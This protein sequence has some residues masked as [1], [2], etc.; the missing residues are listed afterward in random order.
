MSA[1]EGFITGFAGKLADDV[2]ERKKEARDYF[3]K[4]VE[5]ART[6][7]LENRR[8][9]RQ[10]VD[11][12]IL[13]AQQ[14]RQINVPTDVIANQIEANP[15]GLPSLYQ[16]AEKIRA[17]VE[18]RTGRPMTEEEWKTAFNVAKDYK[19]P[20]E[21]ISSLI[22]RAYSPIVEAVSDPSSKDDLEGNL[23]SR[24]LG[25]NAMDQARA[26]LGETV[27][28]DGMTAEQLIS[29]GDGPSRN[30]S[31][32][33]PSVN[34]AALGG[35]DQLSFDQITQTMENIEVEADKLF[36]GKVPT[37]TTDVSQE[38]AELVDILVNIYKTPA[39]EAERL[40]DAYF[41][42]KGYG[43]NVTSAPQDLT[44]GPESDVETT[45][46]PPGGDG[47]QDTQ[48]PP[49]GA[50]TASDEPLPK[51]TAPNS[52]GFPDS[53][54]GVDKNGKVVKL[55]LVRIKENGLAVYM[56]Q[57][58]NLQGADGKYEYAVGAFQ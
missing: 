1:L 6:T 25:F 15:D 31:L 21:D 5:Y 51:V 24:M 32:S 43:T 58:G 20:D 53:F 37:D 26:K 17:D 55:T 36:L 50:P 33:A 19:A 29:Q 22:T 7:G 41:R 45:T 54:E 38:R 28:A 11:A 4:Q 8:R 30:T 23:W 44:G 39:G 2:T 57:D 18:A 56:D 47:S 9:V 40:V 52:T 27:I 13:V 48:T 10:T 46:P 3:N 12:G 49:V 16:T 35:E 34:Y 14:L 42:R